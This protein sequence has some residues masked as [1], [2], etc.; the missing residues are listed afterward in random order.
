MKWELPSEPEIIV[1]Y[2]A[3]TKCRIQLTDESGWLNYRAED[4]LVFTTGDEEHVRELNYEIA[5]HSAPFQLVW[6]KE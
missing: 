5:I 2:K 4:Q 3:L 1:V 6:S